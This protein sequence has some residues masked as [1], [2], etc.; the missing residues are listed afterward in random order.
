MNGAL[1]STTDHFL[2]LLIQHREDLKMIR[3]EP[4][5]VIANRGTASY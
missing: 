5:G 4:V 2:L 1:A 3:A